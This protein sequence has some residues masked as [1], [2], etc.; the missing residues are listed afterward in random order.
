VK[1]TAAAGRAG[2]VSSWVKST[3][4]V[5]VRRAAE[6]VRRRPVPVAAAAA[7]AVIAVLAAVWRRQR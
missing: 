2:A 6:P 4:V 1:S 3:G 7:V 5:A